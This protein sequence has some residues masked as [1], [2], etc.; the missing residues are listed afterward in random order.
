MASATSRDPTA[1]HRTL[2]SLPSFVAAT[3]L[4]PSQTHL[5]LSLASVVKDQARKIKRRLLANLAVPL[6]ALDGASPLPELPVLAFPPVDLGDTGLSSLS[7]SGRLLA[8]TRSIKEPASTKPRRFVEILAGSAILEAVEV[9]DHHG[10]FCADTF[11]ALSWAPDERSLV[12]VAE[13]KAPEEGPDKFLHRPDWGE[14][15]TKKGFPVL[16]VIN[17]DAPV[18]EAATVLDNIPVAAS[19][20]GIKACHNRSSAIYKARPDGTSLENLTPTFD[21]A[22]SPRL[23]PDGSRL[24][25]LS[26]LAPGPHGSTAK[27]AVH[28][29]ASGSTDILVPVVSAPA[30]PDAFPGLYTIPPPPINCWVESKEGLFFIVG[31]IW[32]SREVI[33][34]ICMRTGEVTNQ[35]PANDDSTASW[36]LLCA[37]K[38]G[39][40]VATRSSP[41]EPPKVMLG[42]TQLRD[43]ISWSVIADSVDGLK[44]SKVAELLD[45]IESQIVQFPDRA[46]DAELILVAP[47]NP[48]G[49]MPLIVWPH[50]GPHTTL[51]GAF[52]PW[53]S[54]LAA[55]G[56]SILLVNYTGSLGFGEDSVR[57]LLGNIG[58]MDVDDVQTA[59]KLILARGDIDPDRV[60]ILGGSHGGFLAAHMI[61][62]FPTLYKAAVLRN[63]VINIG[64]MAA[65]TDIP[66]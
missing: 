16:V 22:R 66:D 6:P 56:Y 21:H 42:K 28:D 9:T 39:Y 4:P 61:G 34:A 35:T 63:P 32:R 1:V 59:T 3:T 8:L 33:L 5:L 65:V 7:P 47:K 15:F 64:T 13:K 24:A 43:G 49:R 55:L 40:I 62:Q 14:G 25:F 19:E 29:I 50:G 46:T 44:S 12:Y 2:S 38:D 58:T 37:T 11:G 48:E 57:K 54:G 10:D 17:L 60:G 27:L 30:D 41:T 20:Y 52:S 36:N 26:N 51:T 23:T 53:V 18:K 31:S 45:T